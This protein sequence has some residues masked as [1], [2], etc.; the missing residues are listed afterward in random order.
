VSLDHL[1]EDRRPVLD[2]Q[3]ED[4]QQIAVLVAVCQN[5]QLGQLVDELI[6]KLKTMQRKGIPLR[7]EYGPD[8]SDGHAY[9]SAPGD[10]IWGDSPYGV[11][12]MAGNVREW[13]FNA[14]GN[15][16]LSP[17]GAWNDPDYTVREVHNQMFS[18][19]PLDRQA[20]NGLRLALIRDEPAA[21]A[22][23]R[24]PVSSPKLRDIIAAG[25]VSDEVFEAYRINFEYDRKPLNAATEFLGSDRLMTHE[26]IEIDAAYSSPRLPIHLYL[27][28]A[29]SPPYQVVLYWP[30]S[31]VKELERYEDFIFQ[32][33]FLLKSGLA[34]AFP[35]Y[36]DAFGRR[37]AGATVESTGTAASRDATIRAVKDLRRAVD[38]LETR[39]DIDTQ[40]FAFF[41]HSGGAGIGA[42]ALAV[43]PR[44]RAAVFYTFPTREQSQADIDP[45]S[46]LKRIRTPVLMISGKFDPFVP[47]EEV[48][49]AFDLIGAA[50]SDKRMIIAPSGH[51]A[52]YD[53]LVRESLA[54]YDEKLEIPGKR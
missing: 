44:F 42:I 11:A 32:F 49:S 2:R 14:D 26:L 47:L 38:Y 20:G 7:E 48:R 50:P 46:Y 16:R 28:T 33:D 9:A 51:Y 36:Y 25:Q 13:V 35:I 6:L 17:G 30:A 8:G 53:L 3:C 4:L 24:V 12:N 27:P 15:R 29:A 39:P 45:V 5:A 19:S 10:I 23:A 37:E 18:L 40:N 43:E 54:W 41:A 52:P 31:I 34:V 1:E 22:A 21:I